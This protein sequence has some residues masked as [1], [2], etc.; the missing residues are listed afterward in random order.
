MKKIYL[1]LLIA[2][3]AFT[4][5]FSQT[6]Q[7]TWMSGDSTPHQ[8][9]IVGTEGVPSPLNK[10]GARY[11]SVSWTDAAGNLWLFG[12]FTRGGNNIGVYGD[13]WKYNPSS[14]EW[15]WVRG[16]PSDYGT[17]GIPLSTNMPPARHY[18]VSW[19]DAAGNFW[20]FGGG[21]NDGYLNDLWK[22]DPSTNLWTWVSGDNIISQVSVF[23][24]KGV[25]S[26]TNKPGARYGAVSWTDAA[27][28]L[29]LMGG[30]YG[31]N[32]LNDLWKYD[33][34]TNLWTWVSGDN[35]HNQPGVYGTK[36]VPSPNNQP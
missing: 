5:A 27:G 10:P 34:S 18:A 14:N 33:P 8:P 2:L 25:P 23:G 19:T 7:W 24:T 16:G 17:K 13:L 15:T 12:G 30:S 20:L 4:T 21:I 28:N 26:P 6:G 22:Y 32:R 3:S 11:G 29:W 36:G 35:T 9:S 1:L 31:N